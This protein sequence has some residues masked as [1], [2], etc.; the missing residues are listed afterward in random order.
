[1]PRFVVLRHEFPADASRT[2]HWDFMLEDEHDLATWALEALPGSATV[3][4][5]ARQLPAHRLAY[6][7]YE[8]PVSGNR[9][10]VHP[11]DAGDFEWLAREPDLLRVQLRGQL[12]QGRVTLERDRADEHAWIWRW[13]PL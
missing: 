10:H 6:L 1:M 5:R 9:G 2:A 7:T 12:L 8:G 11:C 3:P 13:E 4:V